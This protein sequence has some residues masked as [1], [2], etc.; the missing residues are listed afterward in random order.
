[1]APLWVCKKWFDIHVKQQLLDRLG[2]DYQ[3]PRL[4]CKGGPGLNLI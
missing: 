4:S 1:M 2:V 3:F